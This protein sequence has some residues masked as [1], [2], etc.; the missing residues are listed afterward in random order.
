[1]S[2]LSTETI[3]HTQGEISRGGFG[4]F[5][6]GSI[7]HRQESSSSE[8]TSRAHNSFALPAET[9]TN[10]NGEHQKEFRDSR[11][12]KSTN[13]NIQTKIH[14]IDGNMWELR[15]SRRPD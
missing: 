15:I 2:D 13:G 12:L 7:N 8:I 1:M 14:W 11:W 9:E 3:Q 5:M 4:D 6:F 10:S